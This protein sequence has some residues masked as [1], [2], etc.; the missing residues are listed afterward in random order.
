MNPNDLIHISDWPRYLGYVRADRPNTSHWRP[1]K[2][3]VPVADVLDRLYGL[4]DADAG[5][6]LCLLLAYAS[7]PLCDADAPATSPRRLTV[8][9]ATQSV[10]I[11][12]AHATRA[13]GRLEQRSL[14]LI[15]PASVALCSEVSCSEVTPTPLWSVPGHQETGT[16]EE[17]ATQTSPVCPFC[18]NAVVEGSGM[19]S[20]C[21]KA[22][23][24]YGGGE[25]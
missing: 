6:F 18:G 25:S 16:P 15:C 17:R 11:R 1:P 3:S 4:S 8:D 21:L 22:E 13:F 24:Q 12:G 2:V 14:I 23:Q 5:V 20:A 10:R 7:A 9:L 19:C